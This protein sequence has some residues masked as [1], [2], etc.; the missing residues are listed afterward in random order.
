[1]KG[2]NFWHESSSGLWRNNTG[3]KKVQVQKSKDLRCHDE[4]ER[5]YEQME[6]LL[7]STGIYS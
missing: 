5:N 3:E 1:M 2:M 7:K 4:R 6:N